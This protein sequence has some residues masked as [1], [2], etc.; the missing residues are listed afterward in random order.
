MQ[1]PSDSFPPTNRYLVIRLLTISVAIFL[2]I[3]YD[4]DLSPNEVPYLTQ[5]IVTSCLLSPSVLLP[6]P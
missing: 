5:L 1:E 6:P 2:K 3:W 4:G